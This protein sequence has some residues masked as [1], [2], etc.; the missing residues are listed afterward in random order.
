MSA[1]S[2]LFQGFDSF[3]GETRSA[4]VSGTS[5]SSDGS[6]TSVVSVCT[7][8]DSVSEAI[9]VSG[10]LSAGTADASV[11]VK[12][13]WVKS[14]NITSTSV[15][16]VVHTVVTVGTQTPDT[17]S[18]PASSS[19]PADTQTFFRDY[20]DSFVSAITTGGEYY[21]AFVFSSTTS[22]QQQTITASLKASDVTTSGSL[23]TSL[24]KAT[25]DSQTN[26]TVQQQ[27]LGSDA[28]LPDPTADAIE[29]FD[30]GA[31]DVNAPVILG[32]E[33]MGY[34][35]VNGLP[36]SIAADFVSTVSNNRNLLGTTFVEATATLSAIQTQASNIKAMYD[37]YNYS[38]DPDLISRKTQIDDDVKALN[39]IIGAIEGN[40]T[41]QT[42]LPSVTLK[43]LSY[44]TPIVSYQLKP[45]LSAITADDFID[46]TQQQIEE[47]VHLQSIVITKNGFSVV[48]ND[49]T[50]YDRNNTGGQVGTLSIAD[51]EYLS[52]VTLPGPSQSYQIGEIQTTKGQ[53][54]VNSA[55]GPQ[56]EIFK[57]PPGAIVGFVG[58]SA[59]GAESLGTFAI[60]MSPT[61]WVNSTSS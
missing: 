38:G 23:S 28:A 61:V 17:Y 49:G 50:T 35:N 48:Y 36:A 55:V 40:V 46:L 16:V 27:M 26:Y 29:D 13:S 12:S 9:S 51:G 59:T 57:A 47:G 6:S 7:D 2:A 1:P 41:T 58:Q 42:Y 11:S 5:G 3:S 45:P 33:V 20:G 25:T 30:F 43:S 19:L 34:E 14:L 32:Y 22:D 31:A 39:A 56:V 24:T 53:S 4:I 10:S 37:A 60:T 8:S 52:Q 18:I 15:T 21:A 44:G 54:V